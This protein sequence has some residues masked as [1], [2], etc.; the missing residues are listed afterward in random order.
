MAP[1]EVKHC[2]AVFYDDIV[3]TLMTGPAVLLHSVNHTENLS[4]VWSVNS[5]VGRM[6]VNENLAPVSFTD[7]TLNRD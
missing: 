4:S 7:W 6:D 2:C 3:Y 5:V 1:L